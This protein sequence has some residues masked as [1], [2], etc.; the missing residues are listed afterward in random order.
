MGKNKDNVKNTA[1]LYISHHF[2]STALSYPRSDCFVCFNVV[3]SIHLFLASN[4]YITV[5]FII[6]H[7]CGFYVLSR[8]SIC[9]LSEGK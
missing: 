1:D 7:L 5:I 4:A 8:Q 2:V 3:V 9:T 6:K